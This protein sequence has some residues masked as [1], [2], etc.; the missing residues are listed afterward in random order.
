MINTPLEYNLQLPSITPPES[1]AGHESDTE[2]PVF[3]GE[4]W[5][6]DATHVK[7]TLLWQMLLAGTKTLG[8]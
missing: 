2:H 6:K 8:K 4:V 1:R 5:L 3:L 7:L